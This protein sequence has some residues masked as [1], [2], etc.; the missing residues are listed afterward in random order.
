MNQQYRAA[1]IGQRQFQ[2]V[3]LK[4]ILLFEG[5]HL[6][7]W[8]VLLCLTITYIQIHIQIQ[9]PYKKYSTIMVRYFVEEGIN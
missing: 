2:L 3:C 7:P 4:T 1:D 9:T 8:H 5:S 6:G